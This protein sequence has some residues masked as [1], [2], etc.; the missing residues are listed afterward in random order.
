MT[1]A[2]DKLV[3]TEEIQNHEISPAQGDENSRF[4]EEE[5]LKTLHKV[6]HLVY[7]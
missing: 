6:H 2:G 3:E 1:N 4:E 7:S 5:S